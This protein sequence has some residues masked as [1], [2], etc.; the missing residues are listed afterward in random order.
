MKTTDTFIQYSF[1]FL[2][3]VRQVTL[4]T[5]KLDSFLPPITLPSPPLSKSTINIV[6]VT[7]ILVEEES[8]VS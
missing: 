5:P 6:T 4:P 2:N 7:V 1:P 3:S 8:N